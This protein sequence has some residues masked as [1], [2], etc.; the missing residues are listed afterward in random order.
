MRRYRSCAG[1]LPTVTD[2]L[3][4]HRARLARAGNDRFDQSLRQSVAPMGAIDI[5]AE[6]VGLVPFLGA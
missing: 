1:A 4:H 5:H 6:Q 3:Q 2:K